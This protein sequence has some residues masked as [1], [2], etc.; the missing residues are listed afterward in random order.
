MSHVYYKIHISC[1]TCEGQERCELGF[2]EE[3]ETTWN[4]L[5][6][7]KDDR[8][9]VLQEIGRGGDSTGLR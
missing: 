3:T 9:M 2:G 1:G 4:T 6:S 5:F 8:K 7:W